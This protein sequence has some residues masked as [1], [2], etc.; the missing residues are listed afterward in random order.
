[1]KNYYQKRTVQERHERRLA[2]QLHLLKT[3]IRDR[4]LL[5]RPKL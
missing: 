3:G 2:Y 4:S 5:K 1:M